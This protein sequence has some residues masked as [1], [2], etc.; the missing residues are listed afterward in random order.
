MDT[1]D[2]PSY[3]VPEQSKL[4][5]F[6]SLGL[7]LTVFGLG[8]WI[9]GSGNG[10]TIFLIGFALLGFVL[11]R[12]FAIVIDENIRGMNSIKLKTSYVWGMGWFIFSEVMFFA[13]FFGALFYVRT[14]ALPWLSEGPTSEILW[15]GFKGEW[16]LMETPDMAANGSDAAMSGPGENMSNPGLSHWLGWL[17]FWNTSILLLSSFTVHFAHTSLKKDDKK[18]FNIWLG[19]TV[20]LGIIFLVLQAEEYR[21]AY[22]DLGLTLNSGIYGTTFFLLTGF[23]GLH[24]TLGTFMLLVQWL[25]SVFKGHF[26][27]DD[28]FGFEASSWYWHFVDVVWLGLFVFVYILG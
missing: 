9:N 24:V 12:W 20:A 28:C 16:P 2:T 4:P 22:A 1:K 27:H 21:H 17:P 23:H 11:Y 18:W 5:L 8:S 3:Y 14:F 19:I 13:A 26:N 25:R 7:F 10:S 6:A 15:N